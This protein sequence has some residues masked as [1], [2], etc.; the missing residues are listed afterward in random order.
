M[1]AALTL[2]GTVSF[3]SRGRMISVYS[4]GLTLEQVEDILDELKLSALL[5][6]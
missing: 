6:A 2:T 1:I 5:F 3:R 4:I